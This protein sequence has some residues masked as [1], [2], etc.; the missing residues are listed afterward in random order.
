MLGHLLSNYN[1][2]G[3]IQFISLIKLGDTKYDGGYVK[4]CLLDPVPTFLLKDCVDIL[5]PSIT[6][7]VNLSLFEGVFFRTIQE[8]SC[9]CPY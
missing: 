9:H 4:S 6:K 3:E 5:L 1:A 2:R 7:L 8:G